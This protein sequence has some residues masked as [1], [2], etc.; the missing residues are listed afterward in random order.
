MPARAILN[1]LEDGKVNLDEICYVN[2]HGTS[3]KIND[4]METNALKLAFKEHAKNLLISST[5]SMTGH[6]LGAAGA[7]EALATIKALQEGIL[8]PTIGL[9]KKDV[10]C[11]LNYI[12]NFA[13]EKDAKFAISS[14]FGFGG[15]NAV[16][17]FKKFEG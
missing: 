5:K 6:M 15:H 4:V 1:A 12:P 8:P 13:V 11:D 14:S 7:V 10:E 17:C 16:L 2:A 9:L 3:T